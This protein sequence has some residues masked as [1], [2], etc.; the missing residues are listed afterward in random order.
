MDISQEKQNVESIATNKQEPKNES[1]LTNLAHSSFGKTMA[2]LAGLSCG[3][4]ST[5]AFG[6]APEKDGQAQTQAL[7]P[8]QT[9]APAREGKITTFSPTTQLTLEQVYEQYNARCD[10]RQD[11]VILQEI[12]AHVQ[13]E[14][15]KTGTPN[16]GNIGE[17]Q[18]A[19]Q[20]AAEIV[21][22]AV[23]TEYFKDANQDLSTLITDLEHAAALTPAA[24][25]ADLKSPAWVEVR[26][27]ENS[28]ERWIDALNRDVTLLEENN[29]GIEIAR[30]RDVVTNTQRSLSSIAPEITSPTWM[31]NNGG[32]VAD[33][34][35]LVNGSIDEF[36]S[37]E[38]IEQYA[39]IAKTIQLGKEQLIKVADVFAAEDAVQTWT[40]RPGNRASIG[41]ATLLEASKQLTIVSQKLDQRLAQVLSEAQAQQPYQAGPVYI[42]QPYIIY[43]YRCHP[44]NFLVWYFN[45]GRGHEHNFGYYSHRHN[46]PHREGPQDRGQPRTGQPRSN[47]PRPQ[48]P[49]HQRPRGWSGSN[50]FSNH[51]LHHAHNQQQPRQGEPRRQEHGQSGQEQGRHRPPVHGQGQ[52]RHGSEQGRGQQGRG[53]RGGNGGGQQFRPRQ[54]NGSNHGNGG[55]NRRGGGGHSGGGHSNGGG[56]RGGGGGHRGSGGRHR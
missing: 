32:R 43:D 36:A 22:E 52:R 13:D 45:I 24:L 51:A 50:W 17:L 16:L 46:H 56:H 23:E 31:R 48:Q 12:V 30:L 28:V 4:G 1:F 41:Q 49:H 5:A 39:P 8:A 53:N 38:N 18:F 55:E 35:R 26:A 44:R 14:Y 3:G 42:N 15:V 33:V 37:F 29:P 34:M 25:S 6:A 2:L 11:L 20:T 54:D 21:K 10:L 40:R 9:P 19:Y 27:V 7:D 47:Q